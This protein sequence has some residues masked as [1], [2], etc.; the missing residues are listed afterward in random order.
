MHFA[1]SGE[2]FSQMAEN[3]CVVWAI[4]IEEINELLPDDYQN[5]LKEEW[6]YLFTVEMLDEVVQC[7][8]KY[9]DDMK[10]DA[11]ILVEPPSI[12]QRIINQYSYFSVIPKNMDSIEA[13]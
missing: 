2:P 5:K 4:D 7:L 8:D 10:S 6:S 9:D 1:T 12:D 3:D 13:F 11:M